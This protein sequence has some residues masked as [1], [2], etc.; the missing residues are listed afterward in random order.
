MVARGV[1]GSSGMCC[2]GDGETYLARVFGLEC[3]AG[4]FD[5]L[6]AAVRRGMSARSRSSDS[7]TGSHTTAGRDGV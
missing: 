4:V 2:S 6:L 1:R 3:W 5:E 7:D